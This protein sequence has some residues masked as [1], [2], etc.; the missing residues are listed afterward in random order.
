[1]SYAFS[2]DGLRWEANWRASNGGTSY[3]IPFPTMRPFN[4]VFHGDRKF[5][6]GHYGIHLG[7]EDN[8]TFLGSSDAL[9]VGYFIDCRRG[10]PTFRKKGS[11]TFFT[12]IGSTVA[13][14][15]GSGACF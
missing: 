14:T 6:Y 15:A 8:L 7:Q 3:V 5:D 11:R 4:I 12:W 2:I 9:I 10:S 1:M 13:H